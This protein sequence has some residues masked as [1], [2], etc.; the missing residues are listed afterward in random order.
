MTDSRPIVVGYDGRAGSRAALDEAV[1]LAGELEASALVVVFSHEIK[2]LGGE[3]ADLEAAIE[4][5]GRAVLQEAVDHASAAGLAVETEMLAEPPADGLVSV[6][7]ARDAQMIVVGSTGEG[8]LRGIL[9]GS[10]A[11]KL[12]HL[13]T[14]P[15]LVVR[16]A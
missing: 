16:A 12:L 10:T 11:Y 14:R 13:S 2:R 9:V 3:V 5:Q 6:A 1:R 4:E 7:D 15:V 8:P